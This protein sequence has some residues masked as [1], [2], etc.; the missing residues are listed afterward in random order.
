MPAIPLTCTA[1][2]APLPPPNDDGI[3]TC[4][5]CGYAHEVVGRG[6]PPPAPFP[7]TVIG[8]SA[9][10]TS[11][12]VMAA[13]VVAIAL[14]GGV[15]GLAVL[16]GGAEEGTQGGPA[17]IVEQ[18]WGVATA[19][20]YIFDNVG[21]PVQRGD[22]GGHDLLISRVRVFPSDELFI[23]ATRGDT[24]AIA[25]RA[26]PYDTYAEGYS[27]VKFQ[28]VEGRVV[29]TDA[30]SV[31]HVLDLA[32][33]VEQRQASL[34]DR[35]EQICLDGGMVRAEQVDERDVLIDPATGAVTAA[36][37]KE[38]C[39]RWTGDPPEIC[40]RDHVDSADEAH[41][42]E[43]L[44]DRLGSTG[45]VPTV[46]GFEPK[47]AFV[48][49]R[50]GVMV[51]VRK[52]GTPLPMAVGF[53]PQSRAVRWTQPV[54]T[55]DPVRVR[56]EHGPADA[57]DGQLAVVYGE[58]TETWHVALFDVPTGARV[59]DHVLRPIFAVDSIDRVWIFPGRV[60]VERT[61]SADILDRADGHL[62]GVIG[63]DSYDD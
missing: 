43:L 30:R 12:M 5:H 63:V 32:T 18:L 47:L 59:W 31:A 11:R 40:V 15:A 34:S 17:S 50:D 51:G 39:I 52:P 42:H 58:G 29:V 48:T 37:G 62:I 38:R 54:P 16:G 7:V 60:V 25:W 26:G 49:G 13:I 9:D 53:D 61:S 21:G 56:D 36:P 19:W 22:A 3:A 8:G 2:G 14:G 46:D 57:A 27:N 28:V 55:I 41:C 4:T 10:G 6:E 23:Q 20:H 33:G 24:A 35:V 1:C 45:G 44:G